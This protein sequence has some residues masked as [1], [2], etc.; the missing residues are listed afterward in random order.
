LG[1]LE[2]LDVPRVRREGGR[3]GVAPFQEGLV[4][5]LAVLVRVREQTAVAISP[6]LVELESHLLAPKL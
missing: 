5:H 2:A 6:L 4:E 3:L 1:L